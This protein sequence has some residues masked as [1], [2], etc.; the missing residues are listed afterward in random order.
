MLY[1]TP[2]IALAPLFILW[3]G[4][5]LRAQVAVVFLVV[6]FPVLIN[7]FVG[8]TST[9]PTLLEV[10]HSF[11][12][13]RWQVFAKVR[14]PAAVPFVVAGL[15][16]GVARGLVGV[17]AAELFGSQAGVG[18]MILIAAQTFDTAAL[19]GG[20]LIFALGGVVAVELVKW[21]ERRVAPWRHLEVEE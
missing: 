1:S 2:T 18:H 3:F 12:A 5:G 11:G 9:D 21:L 4:I 7:T 6:V 19:F 8:L 16:M 17:V 14:F 13:D 15:R 10:A 20:V